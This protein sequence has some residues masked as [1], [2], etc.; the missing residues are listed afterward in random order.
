MKDIAIGTRAARGVIN[1]TQILNIAKGVVKANNPSF[2]KE[3]GGTH[4]LID[5]REIY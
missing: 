1:R 4:E 3:F 5:E 2:L